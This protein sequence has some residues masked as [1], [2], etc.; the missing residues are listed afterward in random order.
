MKKEFQ[1]FVNGYVLA[2]LLTDISKGGS[3]D[4]KRRTGGTFD[5]YR[6]WALRNVLA[7]SLCQFSILFAILCSSIA[8][9]VDSLFDQF[10]VSHSYYYFFFFHSFKVMIIKIKQI[11]KKKIFCGSFGIPCIVHIGDGTESI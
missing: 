8:I 11:K 7:T 4:S 10:C 6:R 5:E 3:I 1:R 9:A 2:H